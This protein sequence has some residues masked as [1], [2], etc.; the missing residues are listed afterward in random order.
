MDRVAPLGIDSGAEL[1]H[2]FCFSFAEVLAIITSVD[3]FEDGAGWSQSSP[4]A[5][6]PLRLGS[7]GACT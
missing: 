2:W 7:G 1:V 3:V 5:R 4:P 6:H